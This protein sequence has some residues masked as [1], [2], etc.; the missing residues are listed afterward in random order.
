MTGREKG[1]GGG[2]YT[3]NHGSLATVLYLMASTS[4]QLRK[5]PKLR[6]S[7]K[8]TASTYGPVCQRAVDTNGQLNGYQPTSS[9]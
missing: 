4:T 8:H 1:V 2:L 6:K 5:C 3:F 7:P 9:E